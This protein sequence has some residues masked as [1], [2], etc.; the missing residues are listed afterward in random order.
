MDLPRRYWSNRL[1]GSPNILHSW[2]FTICSEWIRGF[3]D[4]S[5]ERRKRQVRH[6]ACI[7]GFDS[8]RSTVCCTSWRLPTEDGSRRQHSK[9]EPDAWVN[10]LRGE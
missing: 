5:T 1:Q 4:L 9:I 7:H 2:R 3:I 6:A 8:G 10:I